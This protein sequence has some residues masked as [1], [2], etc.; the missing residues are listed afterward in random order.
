[1]SQDPQVRRRRWP[2][3]TLAAVAIAALLVGGAG[4]SFQSKLSEVQKNDNASY[5]PS[6]AESTEV[7]DESEKFV[8]DP[9][10]PGFV[11]LRSDAPLTDADKQK[12]DAA[13]TAIMQIPG[14]A[15]DDLAPPE[16]SADGKVAALYV[17]LESAKDGVEIAG[18]ELAATEQKILDAAQQAAP[19]LEILP[20]GSAGLLVAFI[21]A[22]EGID[23]ALLGA[24]LIVVVLILLVVYRSPFIWV[25]PLLSALLALGAAS[26]VIYLLADADL[27]TLTG[28]SQGILFVL[29]IGAGTDYALL[30]ISRYREELHRYDSRF[31]AMRR[32]WRES[33]PAITASA[34]TVILGVL[35]LLFS[36]LNSNRSL[37][38]VAAIGIVCTYVVMMSFLPVALAV[39]GRWVFWPRTPHAD[40]ASDLTTHGLWSRIAKTVTD[41]DRP[42]W[43][44]AT[45]LLIVLF[46]G[47]IGSLKTGGLSSTE[48]FTTTPDA[49]V[50]QELYDETFDPGAGTPVVIATND[51]QRQAVIDAASAVDGISDEP[52]AVCP[53]V[54]TAKVAELVRQNPRAAAALQQSGGG[55]APPDL[56]VSPIDGRMIV[57]ATLVD[58]YDSPAALDT[59]ERV[60][61]AVHAV[62][63][64][65]A[66]VGGST[67]TT[68]DVQ[69][70]SVHDRNLIIPIVLAVILVVLVLLLRALVV[71]IILISTVVL[72]FAATLGVSGFFFTHVFGFPDSDPAFP[73][74]AFIFLVALGIDYNIFLM[75]RVR[76]ETLRVG[77]RP[78]IMRGLTVT[79]GVITSAGVVLAATFAVL[80]I[81]P[82]VFLAEVGFAVAFGVL[83]DTIVVRSILV[84]AMSHDIGRAIWWPSTLSRA[85]ADG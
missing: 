6:S 4:G 29:V 24:A 26:M 49:V 85:E 2:G 44:G 78:G 74:Y 48:N 31:D 10:I 11:L 80:G 27:L 39:A 3:F 72:S 69:T 52:G 13:R 33:A 81:L 41:R 63:G 84:P 37:G 56:T 20:A 32:A 9:T 19:G 45:V 71:P 59:V 68:V 28:Q 5:L 43:I 22:F 50:G 8:A 83:L 55:C 30:L 36:E 65:D 77:T 51:A 23:G 14:V 40:D 7:A 75:T 12:V 60:R 34:G 18:D 17:P 66:L 53:Q 73:L 47:G 61:A 21:D 25:F 35:C 76:E 58:S 1:M 46:A 54:D 82:L 15:A 79:G 16:F 64:A 42:F 67:A 70:A 62:P 57:N 38:P